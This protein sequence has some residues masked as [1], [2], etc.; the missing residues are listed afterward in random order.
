MRRL[1]SSGGLVSL[2]VVLLFG[3]GLLAYGITEEVPIGSIRGVTTMA[4][5][6][7]TLKNASVVL[8]PTFSIPDWEG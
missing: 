3:T 8:R 5:S 1:F 4:E 2:I 6:G 7:R